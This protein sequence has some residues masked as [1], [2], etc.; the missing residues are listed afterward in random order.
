LP[1]KSTPTSTYRPLTTIEKLAI[2]GLAVLT[3]TLTATVVMA[4]S[5]NTI[6]N[7]DV[8]AANNSAAE[9]SADVS[10]ATSNLKTMESATTTTDFT[11]ASVGLASEISD[12]QK[13]YNILQTSPVLKDA[14]TNSK[15]TPLKAKWSSYASFVQGTS[16]DYKTLGP[17]LVGLNSSQQNVLSASRQTSNLPAELTQYQSL[18]TTTSQQIAPLK[19]LTAPDQQMLAALETYIKSSNTSIAQAQTDVSH[20][21]GINVISADITTIAA[22]AAVFSNT[23]DSLITSGS[24]TLM[25]LDPSNSIST[26]IA[27]LSDLSNRVNQ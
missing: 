10:E 13:Q 16:S 20:N 1:T 26:F 22:A 17:L 19:M 7:W 21:K 11:T 9:L 25:Q 23:Q 4:V 27:A 2:A 24:S 15:F 5:R 12:A 14:G 8:A 6:T 3:I 18:I